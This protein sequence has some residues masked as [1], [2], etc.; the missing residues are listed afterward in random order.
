MTEDL[1]DLGEVEEGLNPIDTKIT[2]LLTRYVIITRDTSTKV[3]TAN[4]LYIINITL[5]NLP[6]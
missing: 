5:V 2:L 6:S 3:Y 1:L 4:S